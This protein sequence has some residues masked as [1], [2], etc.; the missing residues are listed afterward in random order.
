MSLV[1]LIRHAMPDI[2]LGE[3]WCLGRTDL[4]LGDIGRMQAALLPYV[5]ELTGKPVYCS[6]L[7]R[8]VET[9]RPL[10]PDPI[11]R[12]GLEEQ[13]MGIWDGLSFTEIMMLYPELYAAR[14]QNPGLMPDSAEPMSS[15]RA[16]ML[17][18]VKR[19]VEE[20]GE[21]IVIVSH[22]SAI[23]SLTGQRPKL[24]H[25][26]IS[27]LDWCGD[28]YDVL[29]VGIKPHPPLT[30]EVCLKLLEAAGT[31][32]PVVDHCRAVAEEA[33]RLADRV[34][35]RVFLDRELLLAAAPLHD[36]VRDL[37]HHAECGARGIDALGYTEVAE[38]I[39]VHHDLPSEELNEAAIL[40]LAD[41]YRQGTERVTLEQ[42]FAA[43]VD[44]CRTDTAREAHAR[45]YETAKQIENTIF[46]DDQ[47]A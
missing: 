33:M 23:D 36:V 39:A 44:R 47:H 10:C 41:K 34:A 30:E 28:S 19:C 3:R 16:R 17:E 29:E 32:A 27:V 12:N 26:S 2:P 7:S 4:P 40:Y 43:T 5:P 42:R 11:I 20:A 6:Y 35:D 21:D 37:P 8:A 31:P 1:Y 46:G 45:R 25:T 24:G 18:A 15:V 38:L 9:A 13:D 14:A 22:K